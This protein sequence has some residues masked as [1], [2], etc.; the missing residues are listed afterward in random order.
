MPIHL[1]FHRFLCHLLLLALCCSTGL[2]H[3]RTGT[4]AGD[5]AS[6]GCDLRQ[7]S[8]STQ[9]QQQLRRLR[10]EY[11]HRSDALVAQARSARQ[12]AANGPHRILNEATFSEERARQYITNKYAIQIQREIETL[13]AQHALLQVLTPQQRQEWMA[14][15]LLN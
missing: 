6:V 3:A 1:S 15:C 11:R 5:T 10:A 7:L 2:L 9:Q 14:Q 4:S 13:R 12:D 8:L